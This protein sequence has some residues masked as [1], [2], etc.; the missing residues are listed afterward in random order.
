MARVSMVTK[1]ICETFF[2]KLKLS[3]TWE[4]FRNFS[5]PSR[6]ARAGQEI[7]DWGDKKEGR[8]FFSEMAPAD[9]DESSKPVSG[10]TLRKRMLDSDSKKTPGKT[11]TGKKTKKPPKTSKAGA[12]QRQG[13]P[14]GA[15]GRRRRK[16]LIHVDPE[17]KKIEEF[18]SRVPCLENCLEALAYTFVLVLLGL[19]C[20]PFA[21]PYI[22]GWYAKD[23]PADP[24]LV[25][26]ASTVEWVRNEGGFVADYVAFGRDIDK[27]VGMYTGG[28]WPFKWFLKQEPIL[29]IPESLIITEDNVFDHMPALRSLQYK[30]HDPVQ[31]MA[32]FL[33]AE[34][35]K[36]ELSRFN[37]YFETL[38]SL[39]SMRD[40]PVLA[41]T[42]EL[43]GMRD[44]TL[45]SE[46]GAYRTKLQTRAGTLLSFMKRNKNLYDESYRTHA[47]AMRA[48]LLVSS[49]AFM[50]A[51]GSF[52]VMVMAP[53]ADLACHNSQETELQFGW[54]SVEGTIELR[55]TREIVIAKGQELN[56]N[57]GVPFDNLELMK[58]RGFAELDNVYSV[59]K[60]NLDVTNLGVS[61]ITTRNIKLGALKSLGLDAKLN[62][63]D[64]QANGGGGGGA[65]FVN[66]VYRLLVHHPERACGCP[67]STI[68]ASRARQWY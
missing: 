17:L 1:Q 14:R 34:Y 19:I 47:V 7:G 21:S 20:Y 26:I 15:Q 12:S 42:D 2:H 57:Y 56:M 63:I 5:F 32:A 37:P 25:N 11:D 24:G 36:G 3:Q 45:R 40:H 67:C 35:S 58:S 54:N 10:N 43:A 61:H 13:I 62:L 18:A 28:F 60:Y 51:I 39:G 6:A 55:M 52:G 50:T 41:Y 53:I 16:I 68:H 22:D 38:P 65:S 23:V 30:G 29:S 46:L 4:T 59:V 66:F 31:R 8:D 48:I 64:P 9:A 44:S 49:R 27:D 33:L